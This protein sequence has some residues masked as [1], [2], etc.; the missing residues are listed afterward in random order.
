MAYWTIDLTYRSVMAK[1]RNIQ[2]APAIQ[3]YVIRAASLVTVFMT[4]HLIPLIS[5]QGGTRSDGGRRWTRCELSYI[6]M[7]NGPHSRLQAIC[8]GICK[9]WVISLTYGFFIARSN[10]RAHHIFNK[11]LIQLPLLNELRSSPGDSAHF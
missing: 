2:E 5:A 4:V 3:R 8:R 9:R 7:H 10:L 1:Q 11:P 6:A